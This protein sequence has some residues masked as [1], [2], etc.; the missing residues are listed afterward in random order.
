M[1]SKFL[2]S[3]IFIFAYSAWRRANAVTTTRLAGGALG[4]ALLVL[5]PSGA[6]ADT[7][8][9]LAT[10][11]IAIATNP[12]LAAQFPIGQT[13]TY[14]FSVDTAAQNTG[15]AQTGYY[16]TGLISSSGSIGSYNFSTGTSN[17]TV[18][19]EPAGVAGA[20]GP[21]D[22]FYF[23]AAQGASALLGRRW[24]A[25]HC[26]RLVLCL[27]MTRRPLCRTVVFLCRF[28]SRCFLPRACLKN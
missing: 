22:I 9:Y 17:L 5:A 20:P 1:K 15:N 12:S 10:G 28:L 16:A 6:R 8:T 26:F 24:A 13:F 11:A 27:G 21:S 19:R 23:T 7:V 14:T 25:P 18:G 3:A 4:V 2:R